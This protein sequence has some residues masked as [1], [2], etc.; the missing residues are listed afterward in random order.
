MQ[1]LYFP[2]NRVLNKV[3]IHMIPLSHI[4]PAV[5]EILTVAF[6]FTKI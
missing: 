2:F 3:N 5:V 4:L 6:G 1:N